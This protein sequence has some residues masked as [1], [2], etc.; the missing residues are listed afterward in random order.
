VIAGDLCRMPHN[1]ATTSRRSMA[2]RTS[3]LSQL[4]QTGHLAL[5][6]GAVTRQPIDPDLPN[7]APVDSPDARH[8]TT[9]QKAATGYESDPAGHLGCVPHTCHMPGCP[10]VNH[11]HSRTLARC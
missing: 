1:P 2:R 9:D 11:G 7:R 4:S 10:R 8:E 3:F 5:D 6:L